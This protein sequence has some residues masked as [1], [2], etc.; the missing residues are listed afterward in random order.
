MSINALQPTA[1]WGAFAELNAVP[2]PSKREERV[3]AFVRGFGESLGLETVEDATG[4][5]LIR[6][7]ATPGR[8]GRP[9]VL[10]QGHLDMVHQKNAATEFDFEREG[11][12]MR[13]DGDWVEADGTTLGADNGIGVAAIM[14][15]LA[16]GG[17][18]AHPP[19]EALF[20]VDEET[21][22][23]GAKGL[24]PGF[25]TAR[26]MLNLDTEDDRELT[27]GCAGGIDVTA[28]GSYVEAIAPAGVEALRIGVRG[29]SGGHSGMQIHEGLANANKLLTR[30][31]LHLEPGGARLASFD[32]G[33]LRNAIPR[34]ATAVIL[35][36]DATQVRE[37][38][39]F[40]KTA[41]AA[42]YASTDP[43][44]VIEVTPEAETPA[45]CL[46]E[47]TQA[48]L[49]RALQACPNGIYRMSPDVPG[50][51]QTSNNLAR[52]RIGGGSYE[53]LCL[54]RSSVDSEK[55]DEVAAIRSAFELA[56]AEV[57]TDGD[58]PGWTPLPDSTLL[59]TMRELYRE[60]F[61]EEP[62]VEACHAGLECGL[63]GEKVPGM[64][65]ISFGPNITGAHSPDERVQVS[66][67]QKFWGFFT[68][69]L[70]RL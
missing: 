41:I 52:V 22:M 37:Q 57:S 23:T 48:Q 62:L 61:G 9:T 1:L 51:V 47:A 45:R 38:V 36:A 54:T 63:I 20:T 43:N 7:P 34:E 28:V 69:A 26:Y 64:E 3:R 50:L 5:I 59:T 11:I 19:L 24:E 25:L 16:D 58:Y 12:R 49:L 70:A 60:R 18:I 10:L 4:N 55:Y 66:S 44:L 42:E 17:A 13:V 8:E 2:R 6:K 40:A 30:L 33:G 27:I 56:G 35:T 53:A 46:P 15:V 65:M 29:L 32:G 14:A 39:A 21:G 31:L 67:V 68:E